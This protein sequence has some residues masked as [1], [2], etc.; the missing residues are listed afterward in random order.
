MKVQKRDGSLQEFSI[1]KVETSIRN[2]S[3]DTHRPITEGDKDILSRA[4]EKRLLALMKPEITS[5]D[6]FEQTILVLMKYRFYDLARAYR[7]GASNR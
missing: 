6:I 4:V 7:E 2:A 3:E 1:G 5:N